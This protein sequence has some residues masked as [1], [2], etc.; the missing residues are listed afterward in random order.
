MPMRY[1]DFA[2]YKN[3]YLNSQRYNNFVKN[4]VKILRKFGVQN[5]NE[6]RYRLTELGISKSYH[7]N[8][9]LKT[10]IKQNLEYSKCLFKED[11]LI[12]D[13]GFIIGFGNSF[14][15][16]VKI[17]IVLGNPVIGDSINKYMVLSC[18]S[19]CRSVLIV[20]EWSL[21]PD[22]KPFVYILITT[23]KRYPSEVAFKESA[24]RLLITCVPKSLDKRINKY[25][26][27]DLYRI[28]LRVSLRMNP[29]HPN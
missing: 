13:K 24:T 7:N 17:P 27:N 9:C 10:F 11:V 26:F 5:F 14:K 8:N 29:I 2:P 22:L 12:D 23:T 19:D 20:D 16:F 18:H 6:Y 25:G 28:C 15:R 3:L 4:D 21:L 1:D